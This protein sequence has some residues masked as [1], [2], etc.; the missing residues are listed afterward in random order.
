MVC[1]RNTLGAYSEYYAISQ[2]GAP[3]IDQD[4][5]PLNGT[6]AWRNV[7]CCLLHTVTAIS[8]RRSGAYLADVSEHG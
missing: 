8:E 3:T 7:H 5:A 2:Y 4:H 6:L 1:R